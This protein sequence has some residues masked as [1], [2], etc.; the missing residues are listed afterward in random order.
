M[1]NPTPTRPCSKSASLSRELLLGAPRL[2]LTLPVVSS[3]FLSS[4]SLSPVRLQPVLPSLPASSFQPKE[5]IAGNA[6][7]KTSA[8]RNIR[9]KVLEQLPFLALPAV[10]ST[11]S[12]PAAPA[13]APAATADSDAEDEEAGAK[14]G[15]KGGKKDKAAKGG[16]KGGRRAGDDEPA[17]AASAAP[18]GVAADGQAGAAGDE[19]GLTVLDLIWPKKETLSLIK[20]CVSPSLAL[21]QSS[22]RLELTRTRCSQPRAHLDLRR[23]RRAPL[24]PALRRP[25]LPDPQGPP[26]LCASRS[27]SCRPST[28]FTDSEALCSPGHAP[29]SRC[30]PR[31]HQ[32]CPLG[33]QHHVVRRPALSP[34]SSRVSSRRGRVARLQ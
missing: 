22:L 34:L 4:S 21:A 7:M 17:A 30:R 3:L 5:H 1:L 14:R 9:N 8:Q 31:R 11:S 13:P 29:S 10:P 27:P 32:V 28:T 6:P 20:W 25:V 33:R 16:K 12:A 15:K 19:E 23:A 26:P 2:A 24:L 18:A